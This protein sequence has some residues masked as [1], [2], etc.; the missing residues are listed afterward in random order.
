MVFNKSSINVRYHYHPIFLLFI[1]FETTKT[2]PLLRSSK[3]TNTGIQKEPKRN[4]SISNILDIDIRCSHYL[5][6]KDSITQGLTI[7]RDFKPSKAP[8]LNNHR[9]TWKTVCFSLM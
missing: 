7:S 8:I 4:H 9:T 2:R 3:T 1:S 6:Q 5:L